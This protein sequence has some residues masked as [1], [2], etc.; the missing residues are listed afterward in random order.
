MSCLLHKFN[1]PK[2]LFR[3]EDIITMTKKFDLSIIQT[4]IQKL[5]KSLNKRII[6]LEG[7]IPEEVEPQ[8]Q[9]SD[10]DEQ[11]E[12]QQIIGAG[13]QPAEKAKTE[14]CKLHPW[15]AD[16]LIAEDSMIDMVDGST[17]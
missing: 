4:T 11:E 9:E 13:S 5:S 14:S 17:T 2:Q 12:E 6:K 1:Q 8:A 10:H 16:L 15:E 3:S 7:L